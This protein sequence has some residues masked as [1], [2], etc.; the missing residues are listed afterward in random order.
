MDP[1]SA[2]VFLDIHQPP[3]TSLVKRHFD[4]SH[5][6]SVPKIVNS[7]SILKKKKEDGLGSFTV[8]LCNSADL[9]GFYSNEPTFFQL[10]SNRLVVV[11]K[12]LSTG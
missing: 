4:R 7:R 9:P 2:V 6:C 1:S 12:S 8:V 11:G 3:Q 10:A 5:G